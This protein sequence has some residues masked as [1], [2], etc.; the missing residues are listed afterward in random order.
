MRDKGHCMIAFETETIHRCL[1]HSLFPLSFLPKA[2]KPSLHALSSFEFRYLFLLQVDPSHV[3]VLEYDDK[4]P[5]PRYARTLAY[6]NTFDVHSSRTVRSVQCTLD[7][8]PRLLGLVF[9]LKRA[10]HSWIAWRT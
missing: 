10:S 3:T 8:G 9:N 7:S 2:K 6:A 1:I 4:Q 5:G